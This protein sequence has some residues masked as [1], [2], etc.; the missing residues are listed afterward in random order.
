M[1]TKVALVGDRKQ[2]KGVSA[3]DPFA[4]IADVAAKRGALVRLDEMLPGLADFLAPGG[5]SN[6][7]A[8]RPSGFLGSLLGGL[9]GTVADNS[10][11]TTVDPQR[12]ADNAAAMVSAVQSVLVAQL[13][14]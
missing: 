7:T 12:F 6:A 8:E 5:V 13:K 4:M 9:A 3:G 1:V 10:Y 2:V 11:K 14:R